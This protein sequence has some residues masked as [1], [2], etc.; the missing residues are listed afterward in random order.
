MPLAILL[1]RITNSVM[2]VYIAEPVADILASATTLIHFPYPRKSCCPP[3][4]TGKSSAPQEGALFF[5]LIR[6][7]L[8]WSRSLPLTVR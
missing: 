4:K 1:P 8:I 3:R 6:Q 2:G 7:V 5:N